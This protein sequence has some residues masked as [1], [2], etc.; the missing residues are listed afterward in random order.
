MRGE[1]GINPVI[2]I[3]LNCSMPFAYLFCVFSKWVLPSRTPNK[4][5]PS[6]TVKYRTVSWR[7]NLPGSFSRTSPDFASPSWGFTTTCSLLM[8]GCFR[9]D[10]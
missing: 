1:K 2:P 8:G 5:K 4:H 9:L 10:V 6:G 7:L 3:T